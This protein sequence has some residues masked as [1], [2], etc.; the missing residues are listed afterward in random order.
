V[1]GLG[2]IADAL[3]AHMEQ[4]SGQL[5]GMDSGDQMA[6]GWLVSIYDK[7]FQ[8][9]HQSF[10][11]HLSACELLYLERDGHDWYLIKDSG[12]GSRNNAHHGYYFYHDDYVKLKM[13]SF[14]AHRDA[15][16]AVVPTFGK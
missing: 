15:V 3:F 13:L 4:R 10:Q 12:S 8:F 9:L 5:I 7:K 16:K 6:P 14:T 11:E 2:A 1:C